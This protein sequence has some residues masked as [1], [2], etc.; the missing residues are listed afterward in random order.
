M[1]SSNIITILIY[2]SYKLQSSSIWTRQKG[3]IL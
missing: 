2:I 3:L 1:N